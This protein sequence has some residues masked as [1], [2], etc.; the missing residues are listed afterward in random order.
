MCLSFGTYI[1][2]INV[3]D[4]GVKL[5]AHGFGLLDGV[6]QLTVCLKSEPVL[7]LQV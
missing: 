7:E 2:V 5:E 4:L 6:S 3:Q 1:N